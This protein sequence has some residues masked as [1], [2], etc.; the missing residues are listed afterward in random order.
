MNKPF[1]QFKPEEYTGRNIDQHNE[2]SI[3]EAAINGGD[4]VRALI[5]CMAG[6]PRRQGGEIWA[7]INDWALEMNLK[8]WNYAF[9]ELQMKEAI[10]RGFVEIVDSENKTAHE[11]GLENEEKALGIY[12]KLADGRT[13][14]VKAPK[15]TDPVEQMT[16]KN[17]EEMVDH[18]KDSIFILRDGKYFPAIIKY[19]TPGDLKPGAKNEWQTTVSYQPI[20]GAEEG[21]VCKRDGCE[22]VIKYGIPGESCR[23]ST[24]S[25][26]PCSYCENGRPFCPVCSW[27]SEYDDHELQNEEFV[28]RRAGLEE[29]KIMIYR[30]KRNCIKWIGPVGRHWKHIGTVNSP[31][32]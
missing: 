13:I 2:K 26:P 11:V 4:F 1:Y 30:R 32:E 16:F 10:E 8:R 31:T 19:V 21:D 14:E 9:F 5:V 23:C 6:Q 17:L 18:F 29:G 22:G 28:K 12:S 25:K 27:D 7:Q 24:T 15:V 3:F 20:V